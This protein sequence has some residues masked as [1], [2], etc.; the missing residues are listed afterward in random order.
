MSNSSFSLDDIG[1]I[2]N[3]RVSQ[4]AHGFVVGDV[5]RLSGTDYVKAQA[6]TAVNAEVA[7]IVSKVIDVNTFKLRIVGRQSGL[8]GLVADTVYYLS[9]VTAGALTTTDPQTIS[10]GFVSK[11]VLL[12]D[13]TSSGIIL[14]YRGISDGG[15]GGGDSTLDGL[16][17]VVI[18]SPTNGQILTYN[19]VSGDWENQDAAAGGG[20][21]WE[22]VSSSDATGQS[23]VEFNSL[24][25]GSYHYQIRFNRLRLVS[26]GTL[27][28]QASADNGSNY[29]TTTTHVTSGIQTDGSVTLENFTA[30]AGIHI[31]GGD[32]MGNSDATEGNAVIDILQL[33]Y[34][35]VRIGYSA[36]DGTGF[37]GTGEA[38][39]TNNV[40]AV[41]LIPES[42]N[43]ASGTIEL[44]RLAKS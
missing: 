38:P 24:N 14:T 32:N 2:S 8:S 7:G 5:L 18:T 33:R 37:I 39:S 15:A 41:R 29:G 30:R 35:N 4:T 25:D 40:N 20:G 11:P 23:S 3:F 44:Y 43:F 12:T 28:M 22:L 26:A 27:F 16:S 6:D 31:S 36:G 19:S 10:D 1:N 9:H 34:L 13:S 42:G 21:A 17:D